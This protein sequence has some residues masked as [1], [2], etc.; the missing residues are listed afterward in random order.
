MESSPLLV[1][2]RGVAPMRLTLAGG[3]DRRSVLTE[4]HGVGVSGCQKTKG[5]DG[6]EVE[7][8]RDKVQEG[9]R[10]GSKHTNRAVS[11]SDSV[12]LTLSCLM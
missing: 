2:L 12:P 4:L 7:G 8:R 9:G 5:R 11:C 3:G 10:Q 6:E 1:V